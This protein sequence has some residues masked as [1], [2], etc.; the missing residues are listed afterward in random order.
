MLTPHSTSSMGNQ[1][2][3]KTTG[4]GIGSN[5]VFN[6]PAR[7]ASREDKQPQTLIRTPSKNN[8]RPKSANRKTAKNAKGSTNAPIL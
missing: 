7:I 8:S 1:Y 4:G 2:M 5:N 6:L 3:N